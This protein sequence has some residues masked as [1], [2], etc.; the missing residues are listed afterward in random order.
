MAAS[1]AENENVADVS[2]VDVRVREDASLPAAI[3]LVEGA[4]GVYLHDLYIENTGVY[5]VYPVRCTD[6]LM[7][8]SPF[9]RGSATASLP[10]RPRTRPWK[11]CT[12]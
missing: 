8:L 10:S 7:A 4:T 1:L 5:G 2:V 9:P 11:S 3:T 6:V 12:C